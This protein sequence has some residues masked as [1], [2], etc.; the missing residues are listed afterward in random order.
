MIVTNIPKWL[1]RGIQGRGK[2]N[3]DSSISKN[4][5]WKKKLLIKEEKIIYTKIITR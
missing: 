1:I 5:Q 3:I 2:E 4:L